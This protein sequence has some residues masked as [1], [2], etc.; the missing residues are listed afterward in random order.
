MLLN[1]ENPKLYAALAVKELKLEIKCRPITQLISESG[2]Q[3]KIRT[4]SA[5]LGSWGIRRSNA[6]V[7]PK[8]SICLLQKADTASWF[9]RVEL[10]NTDYYLTTYEVYMTWVS[11]FFTSRL[12]LTKNHKIISHD[13]VIIPVKFITK[14]ILHNILS[15]ITN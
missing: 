9:T 4:A 2:R 11:S 12:F 8:H 1:N 5:S 7:K 13:Q 6:V 3:K 15:N 10:L 14:V